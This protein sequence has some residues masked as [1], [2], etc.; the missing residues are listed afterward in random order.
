MDTESRNPKYIAILALASLAILVVGSLL[1]PRKTAS[2]TVAVPSQTEI[3]RLRRLSQRGSLESMQEYLASV[4]SD[5]EPHVVRLARDGTSGVAW[6]TGVVVTARLGWRFPESETLMTPNGNSVRATTTLCGPH[7]PHAVLE[8]FVAPDIVPVRRRAGLSFEPGEWLLAVWRNDA[9]QVF[10]PGHF[11]ATRALSCGELSAVEVVTN[12]AI[13]KPMAGGGL[14]DLDGNLLAV[15]LACDERLVAV[16]VGSL[17]A[18]LRT[19]LSIENRMLARFGMRLDPLSGA[20]R[21]FFEREDGALVREVWRRYPADLAGLAAGDVIVEHDGEPVRS[22]DDLIA[23]LLPTEQEVFELLVHRGDT[24]LRVE[25]PVE[26]PDSSV[27]ADDGG[28]LGMVWESPAPGYRIDEVVPGSAAAE[29]GIR[30]GDRL[31]R[32]D[33]TVPEDLAQVQG[34]LS[35]PDAEPTFLELERDGR[36][37]GVLLEGPS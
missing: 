14:F 8:A 37:W 20:E 16:A 23:L 25:L 36:R 21:S 33:N 4:A 32:L 11:I 15:L 24:S 12:I 17:E 26:P 3:S 29:A 35:S 9:E 13:T 10:A 6:D 22:P 31:L 2:E 27:D 1:K 19:E 7:L 5:L 34:T 30:A 18:G 28:Q